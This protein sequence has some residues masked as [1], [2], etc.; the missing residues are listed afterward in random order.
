MKMTTRSV[1]TALAIPAALSALLVGCDLNRVLEVQPANLIPAVEL[2]TPQNA[3]LLA[4][5]AA[6]DF[7]CAFNAFVVVGGLI[8]EELE[9]GL[10]TAARWPYD[11][12][13]ITADQTFYSVNNCTGLGIYAPLQAARAGSN[14]VGRLL[15]G[16]TDAEVPGRQLLLARMAAYE[17]W[18]QL[19][20]GETFCETVFSTVEG[21]K[22]LYAG[23]ITRAQAIDAA[24]T[25][26]GTAIT[27]ATAV[28]GVSADSIRFFAL[29]GRAR[30]NLDKGDL[31]AARA[32][33]AA[34][35]AGVPA[36]WAW[37]VT[38]S[39]ASTRRQN[40]VFQENGVTT[41]PNATVGLRYRTLNDPRVPVT[42][43]NRLSSGTNIPL[44]QQ[45]KYTAVTSPIQLASAQEMQL[46]IA[47]ADRTSNPAN[48]VNIIN[49]FRAAGNQGTYTGAVTPAALLT[50]IIDQRR[51]ALFL[52][53]THFP[54]IIRYN[55]T[56]TPAQGAA[57]PW[58]QTYGPATGSALCLPLPNVEKD[59]N[60]ILQ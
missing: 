1:L 3:T 26:F 30:A 22:V 13:N 56:L 7:D 10:Q 50:E 42:N 49:T 55:L 19:F 24:I 31:V 41:T 28:G 57:T 27:T 25:T 6:A 8:G 23:R 12:R 21:E 48:T 9:D 35:V 5:G 52:T 53:G 33:A 18:G 46:V 20:L 17:A 44:W 58:G 60:P 2:E 37:N 45:R 59:N 47:E 38:N 16:W 43:L 54:D 14:N 39:N 11:Q 36:T 34:V 32:D 15:S 40:R 51:R 4:T 29:V